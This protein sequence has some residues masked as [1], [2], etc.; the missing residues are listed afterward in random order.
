MA[1]RKR[2][3]HT[4]AGMTDTQFDPSHDY[5]CLRCGRDWETPV[6]HFYKSNNSHY[7][8]NSN[9]VPLCRDCVNEMFDDYNRRYGTKMACI[10]MCYKLDI[11][12]YHSLFDSINTNNGTDF[13]IGNMV[14]SMNNRQYKGQNFSQTLLTKELYKNDETI[15]EEKEVKWSTTEQRNKNMAIEIVGY[16]P[17]E[18]HPDDDRKFLF[19][20]LIKY[21][22]DDSVVDDHYKLSQI[23][24][25]VNN[26]NQIRIYDALISRMNPRVDSEEIDKLISL[27]KNLVAS[28]DKIAKEN[29]VSVKNRSDKNAGRSTLTFLMRDLR[30]KD[31]G[32]AEENY[33]EQLRS[34]SS[35]WAAD[36]SFKA[37]QANGFFDENDKEEIFESQRQMLTTL[38]FEKDD[39]EEENRQLKL[40]IIELENEG[41]DS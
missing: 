5:K 41:G 37:I 38:Q 26:N 4:V 11:P 27:K 24:Q 31:F 39:L 9:Y 20:E 40:R 35:Q 7:D 8:A 6:G 10:I 29:E 33:Y 19:N 3:A 21:L 12:F 17:F 22:N 1:T 23:I 15:R 28:T 18:G 36:M 16:D 14:R 32:D 25:I 2:R 30:E 34:V 13:N